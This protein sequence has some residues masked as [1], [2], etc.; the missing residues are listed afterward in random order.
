MFIF[1]PQRRCTSSSVSSWIRI[2]CRCASTRSRPL[3]RALP[4]K[5]ASAA[6]LFLTRYILAHRHM[7][8]WPLANTHCH[9]QSC[10]KF[11]L[12]D[13]ILTQRRIVP[14]KQQWVLRFPI[15]HHYAVLSQCQRQEFLFNSSI[16]WFI[17]K[18]K[19]KECFSEFS[20]VQLCFIWFCK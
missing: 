8:M 16:L 10:L 9:V 19:R 13:Y 11:R 7:D 18:L 20:F 17:F 1:C 2:A 12:G 14:F 3:S 15:S 6:F 4:G 5:A